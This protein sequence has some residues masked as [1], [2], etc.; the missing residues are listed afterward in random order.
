MTLAARVETLLER[1]GAPLTIVRKS[2][3]TFD[4][5]SGKRTG[6]TDTTLNAFG[7]VTKDQDK[8]AN[9]LR[10]VGE[11]DVVLIMD[12]KVQPELGDKITLGEQT[13]SVKEFFV[14][15]Y[16]NVPVYYTVRLV[17]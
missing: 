3:A 8:L 7:V 17:A 2:G 10:G 15:Y 16:E 12:T 6:G 13:Y 4:E 9:A 5:V 1:K 14:Q 11:K